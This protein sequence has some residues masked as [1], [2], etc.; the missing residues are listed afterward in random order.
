MHKLSVYIQFVSEKSVT[1]FFF[2]LKE[3]AELCEVEED[4]SCNVTTSESCSRQ[5]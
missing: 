5:I 2:S 1:T 3:S 4:H